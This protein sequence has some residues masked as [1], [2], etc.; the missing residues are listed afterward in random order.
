MEQWFSCASYSAVSCHAHSSNW[1]AAH[2]LGSCLCV[3]IIP[4]LQLDASHRFALDVWR[5]ILCKSCTSCFR[6]CL[7]KDGCWQVVST[8]GEFG[9]VTGGGTAVCTYA[10][11]LDCV[12]L[13]LGSLAL[14]L[15]A[16]GRSCA[17]LCIKLLIY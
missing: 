5:K 4:S 2:F 3:G 13:I 12:W 7:T 17:S 9:H 14:S 11:E 8:D 16:C 6:A 15:Q 1:P 10:D